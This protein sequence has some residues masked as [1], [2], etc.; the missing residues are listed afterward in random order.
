MSYLEKFTDEERHFLIS[1]PY[2]TGLWVSESDDE[3]GDDSAEAEMQALESII[4]GYSEDFL[5]S[6]FV[7]ELMRATLAHKDQWEAWRSDLATVP[8]DCRK[9]V[10]IV[11]AYLETREVLSFKQNLME[12]ATAVAM[13]YCE[14]E[15]ESQAGKFAVYARHYWALFMA[16]LRKEQEPRLEDHVNISRAERE[17]LGKLSGVLRIDLNGAPLDKAPVETAEVA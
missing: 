4:T 1:L 10:E 15:E 2:R 11:Q 16:R 14:V 8:E 9:A 5:K 3:G 13:A 12:I 6:E 17:V 7:E